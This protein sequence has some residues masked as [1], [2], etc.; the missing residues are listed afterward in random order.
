MRSWCNAIAA[1]LMLA[2]T[3]ASAFAVDSK[4]HRVSIQIDQNDPEVMNLV[5][6]NA[7]NIM[8]QYKSRGET[9]Q[10]EI[11]AY[12]SGLHM[13]RADTSPVKDRIK[14]AVDTSFPSTIKFSACNNTKQ[15]MEKREGKAISI[16]SE[17][18]LVPSGAVRLVELQEQGWQY[19]RP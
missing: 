6:N 18:E 8:E 2:L 1:A 10:I 5:L 13:L 14:Q 11:V 15:G 12:G 16:I 7:N 4:E 17:S 19:L 9:A 3:S